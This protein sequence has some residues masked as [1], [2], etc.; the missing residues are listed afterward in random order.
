MGFECFYSSFSRVISV[1]SGGNK[2]VGDLFLFLNLF[3]KDFGYFIVHL[4]YH[5]VEAVCGEVIVCFL[6]SS[7]DFLGFS[8]FDRD[9]VGVICIEIVHDQ[10]ILV[11]PG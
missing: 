5:G 11:S 10:D 3:D 9:R 2:L 7:L 6:E 4:N 8:G 1:V